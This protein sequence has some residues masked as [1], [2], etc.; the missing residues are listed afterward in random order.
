LSELSKLLNCDVAKAP[1]IIEN[2]QKM[3]VA[4]V[5]P[6]YKVSKHI[7]SVIEG[8]GPEVDSI[9]VVDD[10]CP[11]QTGKLVSSQSSDP[12][13]KVV[14]HEV[15][16]GVGG[17]TVSGYQ[18]AVSDGIEIVVKV[19]GDGQMDTS[20]IP[21]FIAPIVNGQADYTKGNR[22]Y[23]FQSLVEMPGVRVFGNAMLSFITKASSGY[24]NLMDPTNGYTAIHAQALK[25]MPLNKLDKRYFFESD[26]LFRLNTIRAVVEEIPMKAKYAD[27]KSNLS[28]MKVAIDFPL[29][30][31]VRLFK[32]LFYSYILRDFNLCSLQLILGIFLTF[33]GTA[34]G[35]Y[36]WYSV[37]RDGQTAST[38]TVM[39][40]ALPVI[41]GMQFLIAAA[42]FDVAN[43]PKQPIQKRLQH[44]I[45][46]GIVPRWNGSEKSGLKQ[47]NKL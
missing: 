17:A 22:F 37:W 45:S 29:K 33:S 26:I 43:V 44:L 9:Y 31:L 12:R 2:P 3:A 23:D 38:G 25:M 14:F 19:D 42:S 11:E 28:I 39:V 18:A 27:E 21:V 10:C 8:I 20:L 15:N 24:W 30:H 5:I 40:A 13:V 4:V 32:R 41:L 36:H 34:F 1:L 16:Q 7:L 46:H 6:C 47:I 35:L